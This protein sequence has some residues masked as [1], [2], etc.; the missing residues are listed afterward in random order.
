MAVARRAFNALVH[1]YPDLEP[2]RATVL[3]AALLHDVGHGPFSHAAEEV[4]H[5]HH[6]TWTRRLIASDPTLRSPLDRYSPELVPAVL[7]VYDHTH[8]LP[9]VW[10]LIS[11]QLD[12]D[13]L[14]YLMRDSYFTGA[15]YGHLDLDRILNALRM[16]DATGNLVVHHKGLAAVEHYL[17]VR[18]FM[19]AQVYN[20]PKNLAATWMLCRTFD[21]ARQGLKA[22]AI[23][24]DATVTTWL[25][26]PPQAWT[27]AD[28]LAADDVVLTYHLHQWRSSSGSVPLAAA[29]GMNAMNAVPLGLPSPESSVTSL[30][31]VPTLADLCR[32]FLDRDLFKA[33]EVSHWDTATQTQ[34]LQTLH[35]LLA[36]QG[37]WPEG[38]CGYRQ[39][40]SRGYTIYQQGIQV[41]RADGRC[42]EINQVSPLVT[43]LTQVKQQTWLIYPAQIAPQVAAL[44]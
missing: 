13:R 10:Q 2:H 1:R 5:F 9:L 18:Y 28:Y 34:Q 6:E 31:L 44:G 15:S 33:R 30:Q 25:R 19:Y 38:Y 23:A 7:S 42:Q 36:D 24:A 3:V 12:C 20:H 14:D 37:L 29:S 32:R 21:L 22:G 16:D 8:P 43:P 17:L 35:R 41:M 11:S 4:F 26:H 39:S 27:L 40:H